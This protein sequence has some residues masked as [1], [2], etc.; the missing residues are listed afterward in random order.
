MAKNPKQVFGGYKSALTKKI[1]SATTYV[2]TQREF[3][4]L[5]E[6]KIYHMIKEIRDQMSKWE[7]KYL[8]DITDT[9]KADEVADFQNILDEADEKAEKCIEDL[10][11]YLKDLKEKASQESHENQNSVT[12]RTEA[13]IKIDN[14]IRPETLLI[15][16]TLEEFNTWSEKFTAFYNHN[17][18]SL[19]GNIELSRQLLHSLLDSKLTNA[20]KT[21]EDV[22]NETPIVAQGGCLDKLRAIFLKESPLFLRRYRF[23]ECT[24]QQG[25]SFSEWWVNKKTKA[26]ECDLDKIT[27]QDI[28]ML[29]LMTGVRDPKLKQ[30]FM[31][32][33]NPTTEALVK[34][35]EDWERSERLQKSMNHNA[36]SEL[37]CTVNKTESNYKGSKPKLWDQRRND[38]PGG[39]QTTGRSCRNCGEMH[40]FDKDRKFCPAKGKMCNECGRFNHFGKVC[41]NKGNQKNTEAKMTKVIVSKIKGNSHILDD[42]EPIPLVKML[43]TPLPSGKP[44]ELMVFPDQGATTSLI[45]HDYAKKHKLNIDHDHEQVIKDVQGGRLDCT[46]STTFNVKYEGND[47]VVTALVSRSLKKECL[48]GWR[49]L[50]RLHIIHED[51][52][53]VLKQSSIKTSASQTEALIKTTV[54]SEDPKK[55]MESLIEEFKISVFNTEGELKPMKG[56]PMKIHLKEGPIKPFHI[57]TPRKIPYAYKEA[58][59]AKLDKDESLGVIEKVPLGSPSAWCLPMSFVPKKNGKDVRTIFD[60]TKLNEHVYR[61]THPFPSPTD[62]VSSIPPDT[63]MLA[64]FDCLHGYWQLELDEESK[65]LTTFLTEFGRYRYRRAPMGLISS[66]D[67]FCARTDRALSGLPG[68]M[69]LVDDILIC[70]KDAAEIMTRTRSV[71]KKC[72]EWGIT[73]SQH[74]YQFGN[75]V[76]FAG[77]LISDKGIAPDPDKVAAIRNFATPENKTDVRAWF[78]ICNQFAPFKLDLK[79][80]MEPLKGLLSEKNAFIWTPEHQQSMQNTKD[81]ITDEKGSILSHFDPSKPIHLYTDASKKGLGFILIQQEEGSAPKLIN[82]G[83]R[84][85]T[86]AEKNYAPVEL[87]CLAIQWA[88]KQSRLYL[89][90]A[91][92]T[93]FTDHKPLIGVFNGKNL[94]AINNTRLQRMLS[95]LLGYSFKVVWIPGKKQTVADALSR[96]PVWMPEEEETVDVMIRSIACLKEDSDLALSELSEFAA[97]DP[98]YQEIMK[99]IRERRELKNLPKNHPAQA[100]KKQ[101]DSMSIESTHGLLLYDDRIVVPQPARKK[102]LSILHLQHAGIIKTYDNAKQLYYWHGMKNEIEDVVSSCEECTRMLP[103][104]PLETKIPT[105]ASR[106]WEAVSVD[107][108]KQDGR[109]HLILTDRYSG[110]AEVKPLTKLD[111]SAIIAVLEDWFIDVGKP[112][113]IRSD[114]GPQFRTEFK[115]WCKDQDIHHELSSAHHHE[116]NGHAEVAVKEM[117]HLLEKTNSWQ[118]FR[119]AL[120]EYRNNP[121]YDHLSPAQWALGRRQ[122]TDIPAL[123]QHYR[124]LSNEEIDLFDRNRRARMEKECAEASQKFNLPQLNIGQEVLIQDHESRRWDT[125]GIVVGKRHKKNR[126]RSYVIKSNGRWY[127][128]NRRRL[129]PKRSSM[130]EDQATQSETPDQIKTSSEQS[131]RSEPQQIEEPKRS[132]RQRTKN[133]RLKE[134]ELY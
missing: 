88:I 81:I 114:G 65:P 48:L 30:E 110:W 69:K 18:K 20:L 6:V 11:H 33:E 68:V 96:A 24:Q 32:Q 125:T 84:F 10:E 42:N 97:N 67:E 51:F 57:Y 27:K 39:Q 72:E 5:I 40:S 47:T 1:N 56:G 14:T 82:S 37:E 7:T 119:R 126:V 23:Q 108:G 61:T 4:D 55:A 100:F 50:Q 115:Q 59:K 36:S 64:V 123:P 103:S 80:S 121:R 22:T 45:S 77:Y 106:P 89:A 31:K 35:A 102:I 95:K 46:G 127:L 73:L 52:P 8:N 15:S 124:R 66:G 16:F 113:R 71:F 62:I 17:K 26:M 107:L 116:S 117:K 19:E 21:E 78:G 83:S 101:W 74:K 131:S 94:D 43:I 90:G 111:T 132:G 2:Q 12:H 85:I 63:K 134:Y 129:R 54:A 98:T 104:Q 86:P 91:D 25:Q 87:E 109:D 70:G 76:K 60:G 13:P 79:N 28:M 41:L 128:R 130:T 92:F 38:K 29:A 122:R 58:A 75:Q 112:E 105:F 120:R 9:L 44:F 49:A 99:C 118:E 53:H 3:S 93:V 133:V 34:I